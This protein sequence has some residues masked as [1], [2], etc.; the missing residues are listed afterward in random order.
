MSYQEST[1]VIIAEFC[2]MSLYVREA[3][4]PQMVSVQFLA[5]EV[6]GMILIIL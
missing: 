3:D 2:F 6:C 5:P 4:I 1:K